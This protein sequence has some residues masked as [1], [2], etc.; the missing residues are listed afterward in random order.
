MFSKAA[1][2]LQAPTPAER[3]TQR[4]MDYV[5]ELARSINDGESIVCI[6]RDHAF[7]KMR[8]RRSIKSSIAEQ[9]VIVAQLFKFEVSG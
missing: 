1:V 7:R 4:T 6:T 8:V 9:F 2:D 5:H 3:V